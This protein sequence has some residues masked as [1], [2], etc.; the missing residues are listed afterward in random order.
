MTLMEKVAQ[1]ESIGEAFSTQAP[2]SPRGTRQ[3]KTMHTVLTDKR[4]WNVNIVLPNLKP[5]AQELVQMV[6]RD[7]PDLYAGSGMLLPIRTIL[8]TPEERIATDLLHYPED[9][10]QAPDRYFRVFC[11][12]PDLAP[13]VRL[14]LT[15]N[16]FADDYQRLATPMEALTAASRIV[17]GSEGL[18]HPT[19]WLAAVSES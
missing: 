9:E 7:S 6:I 1:D 10:I 12:V 19:V 4:L 2:H 8:P 13:R 17:R 3:Q 5:S 14:M 16:D 15:M 11:Q 18:E